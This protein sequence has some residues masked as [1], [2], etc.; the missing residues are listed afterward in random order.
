MSVD[1]RMAKIA[2]ANFDVVV[3]N[4]IKNAKRI[5]KLIQ[6]AKNLNV[7]VL[8]FPE[9]SLTGYTCGD[10][11]LQ[12]YMED[13]VEEALFLLLDT[14]DMYMAPDTILVIGA[15]FKKDG[16]L[17]NTAVIIMNGEI[18][19]FVPKS[20][21]PNYAEFYEKRWFVPASSRLSDTCTI[22]FDGMS[23]KPVPFTPNLIVEGNNG[24]RMACEICEDL[25][26][27]CP[28]SSFHT[29]HGAN[30]I[31]NPSAS[32]EVAT[33]SA[34]RRDLVKMQS[35]RCMCAYAYCSS[36]MGESTTDL[37]FSGHC[38]IA[39]NGAII[40]ERIE[41]TALMTAVIDM[42]RLENDR[43]KYNSSS[44]ENRLVKEMDYVIVKGNAVNSG[45]LHKPDYVNP[46]PFVPGGHKRKDRCKEILKLQETGL[47][48][49]IRK[50]GIKKC[51]IGVSGG[52]DSTLA[53]LVTFE[54]FH[55]LGIPSENIIGITMP[56]FGTTKSTKNN[57][58]LLME[59]LGITART[60]DIKAACMQHFKDIGHDTEQ[61]DVT[62]ENVQARERTQILMD[63]A[64]KEGG[65]VI[66][67]GDMSELALG[68]CTYNGDHMSMYSVNVG[69]PKTLVKYL[70]STYGELHPD[71][72]E[73][74]KSICNTIISPE[75]LPPDTDGNITQSTEET[76]G[77]YDLHDFFLYHYLRNGFGKQKILELAYIAFP[78]LDRE[79]IKKTQNTFYRRFYS[80][81][82]KRS[83]LPD[84]PKI[85]TVS[86]S[87][88]GDWRMPSD[89]SYPNM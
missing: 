16:M 63:I 61:Y 55:N 4:P 21:I 5:G 51:V 38:M 37:I 17:F 24:I 42:E 48:E 50:I 49:R 59:T 84:G 11:F 23:E 89:V 75:L 79:E 70:V 69:V 31:V 22:R 77:K 32:N 29:M 44:Y 87:P 36:G 53:L 47:M 80:Q 13:M 76:I 8:V 45:S 56:G 67:T 3:G 85:G 73:I 33:K 88:R 7:D 19:G 6:E 20:F 52:L 62:Y 46:F 34:Y 18:V 86:L 9:L 78:D 43:V 65:L 15:P 58:E 82:F 39:S 12:S 54:A 68:W 41:E 14:A 40:G 28:P 27:N 81:Q 25:W 64:N 57:S 83:C 2:T 26:V 60:I 72:S 71:L 10:L 30:L 35:G 74:L 66:G 1:L